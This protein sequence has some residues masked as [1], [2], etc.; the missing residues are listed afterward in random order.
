MQKKKILYIITKSNW[1]GAQKYVHDLATSNLSDLF[2]VHVLAGGD[3]ELIK[4]LSDFK[5]IKITQSDTIQ[6]TLNPV[7]FIKIFLYIIKIIKEEDP[8]IIH[9]NSSLIGVAGSLAGKLLKKKIIFTAHGWP[10]NENRYTLTKLVFRFLM[11]ITV[12]L[13]HKVIAV[14]ENIKNTAP[15]IAKINYLKYIKN[16]N[17]KIEKIQ[18]IYPGIEKFE[19]KNLRKLS[20]L[21]NNIHIVSVGEINKNKN[22][23]SFVKEILSIENAL[24]I[25][26]GNPVNKIKIHY[27]IIGQDSG[28]KQNI[29][30]YIDGEEEAENKHV[31]IINNN[32][33]LSYLKNKIIFHGHVQSAHETLS[34]YDIFILPS[35]TEALGYV[36]LEA[37]QNNI[38]IVA[39]SVGGVPEI[40]KDLKDSYLYTHDHELKDIILQIVNKKNIQAEYSDMN[41]LKDS[42]ENNM[43][44]ELGNTKNFIENKF[45]KEKMINETLEIYQ[46][47]LASYPLVYQK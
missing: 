33:K 22:H 5:N 1:G 35:H 43:K 25:K 16:I 15:R 18:V 38:P 6:N 12:Q 32:S 9:I 34:Q 20:S 21:D 47:A 40:I 44:K 2:D 36:V 45:S 10:F 24:N 17:I 26:L 31:N 23:I 7:K 3:G 14:S 8:D 42:S 41:L 46:Q 4:K 30:N 28:E 29:E 37:L 27:H 39:R 11:L 13:S 19:N